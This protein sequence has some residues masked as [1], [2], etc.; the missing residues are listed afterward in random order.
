[1]FFN[2]VINVHGEVTQIQAHHLGNP[3]LATAG[4]WSRAAAERALLVSRAPEMAR[5]CTR[6][7]LQS[8]AAGIY[9][10]GEGLLFT[11]GNVTANWQGR[12]GG[13]HRDT[14]LDVAHL[15]CRGVSGAGDR[16]AAIMLKPFTPMQHFT[17][18][19]HPYGAQGDK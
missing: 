12:K 13:T 19:K 4:F 3:D 16:G 8:A 15:T 17:F 5:V 11:A 2:L 10:A 7:P 18:P 6:A 9:R 1:M 14:Y